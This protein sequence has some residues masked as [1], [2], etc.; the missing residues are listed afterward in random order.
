MLRSLLSLQSTPNAGYNG[1]MNKKI[2]YPSI[3]LTALAIGYIVWSPTS[4]QQPTINETV[5]A[6]PIE[7]TNSQQQKPKA[8]LP[9][10][11]QAPA[12]KAANEQEESE[13]PPE[14][15]FDLPETITDFWGF[16]KNHPQLMQQFEDCDLRDGAIKDALDATNAS[17][18]AMGQDLNYV[19]GGPATSDYHSYDDVTIDQL[20]ASGDK[21]AIALRAHKLKQAGEHEKARDEFYRATLHGDMAS[22][23]QLQ[24][25]YMD[26]VHRTQ[27]KQ[28]QG[29]ESDK[30]KQWQIEAQ[31]WQIMQNDWLGFFAY[32]NVQEHSV[33]GDKLDDEIFALAQVRADQ[34]KEGLERQRTRENIPQPNT[35]P[36]EIKTDEFFD[37]IICP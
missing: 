9:S 23:T 13:L 26:Q 25:L 29:K 3:L 11:A 2:I 32:G 36:K 16:L 27:S 14:I 31:A 30:I 33:L 12:T 8:A 5:P 22:A 4:E 15:N 18:E 7:T 1:V 10:F 24:M 34:I 35:P 6:N 28:E 19:N 20:A 17:Y 37:T 21:R